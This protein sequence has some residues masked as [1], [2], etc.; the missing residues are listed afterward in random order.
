MLKTISLIALVAFSTAAHAQAR[1]QDSASHVYRDYTH[2]TPGN[3]AVPHASC[4]LNGSIAANADG[5]GQLLTC[6]QHKW[7]EFA[8]AV[9]L[10][11]TSTGVHAGEHIVPQSARQA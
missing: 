2:A 9:S 8:G 11:D 7:T 4:T 10:Q 1:G 3:G 5:S 6:K